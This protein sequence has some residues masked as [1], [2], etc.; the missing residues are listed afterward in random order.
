MTPISDENRRLLGWSL[1]SAHVLIQFPAGQ[2]CNRHT[3]TGMDYSSGFV[4]TRP[5]INCKNFV[6]R[7]LYASKPARI[8]ASH[9]RAALCPSDLRFASMSFFQK[10]D[11]ENA[12]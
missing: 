6:P 5:R 3:R 1:G 4:L 7:F 9:M 8:N 10:L 2:A 12:M 11:H